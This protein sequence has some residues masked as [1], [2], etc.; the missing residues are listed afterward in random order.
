MKIQKQLIG[1][2]PILLLIFTAA[3]CDSNNDGGDNFRVLTENDFAADE[4]LTANP[5]TDTIVKFLEAPEDDLQR[6]RGLDT[7]FPGI[8]IFNISYND[9]TE[10][11]FCLENDSD[12]P[13]TMELKSPDGNIIYIT[14]EPDSDCESEIIEPGDYTV[15][16]THDGLSDTTHIIYMVPTIIESSA[17]AAGFK[18]YVSNILGN[19][20]TEEVNAQPLVGLKVQYTLTTRSCAGCNLA[21][22]DFTDA[23]LTGVNLAGADLTGAI[24]IRS[25]LKGINLLGATLVGATWCNGA[26]CNSSSSTPCNA[27][28]EIS[29]QFQITCPD[30]ATIVDTDMGLMWQKKVDGPSGSCL[31]DDKLNSVN[32]TCNW[33]DANSDMPGGWLYKLNNS[34]SNDPSVDCS[35][36][37]DADCTTASVGGCCGFA[38]YRD[39]RLPDSFV[40]G[41]N[42]GG[43]PESESIYDPEINSVCIDPIFEPTIDDLY[44]SSVESGTNSAWTVYCLTFGNFLKSTQHFVRAV[45][46]F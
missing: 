21:G 28:S 34:C 37:G 32:A 27:V 29:G 17:K 7:G 10:Q 24:F 40:A 18:A 19:L 22:A 38:C 13:Y 26:I 43:V 16:L 6:S 41:Q 39:W 8:D 1:L 42:P 3:A 31:D 5:E 33:N 36:G 20:F 14:V 44:W 30:G 25:N 4:T 11:T 2:F 9:T 15:N 45:R 35:V 46:N 23:D 12:S